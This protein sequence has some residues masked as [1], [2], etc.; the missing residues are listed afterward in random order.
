MCNKQHIDNRQICTDSCQKCPNL[1]EFNVSGCS[2]VTA[3]SVVA[4]SEALVFNKDAHPINLDLR[5][6]SF[7]SIELSRHLCNPLLQ[8][9]PCWRPQ[10]VTLT[11]GFDR[12][13][14]V[15]ENTEKHDLVIVVY[16]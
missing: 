15:L 14:I 7:K 3:L 12:P 4:F 8:C 9:G 2:E 1:K 13:A 10:A 11:I 6:T 5:N 16:V